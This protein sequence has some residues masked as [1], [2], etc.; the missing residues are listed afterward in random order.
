M[1]EIEALRQELEALKREVG[2][3]SGVLTGGTRMP[4]LVA[5][6][7]QF[8]V[9]PLE[10]A[11]FGPSSYQS[12]ASGNYVSIEFAIEI[13]N[14]GLVLWDEGTP[15]EFK[16]PSYTNQA[17]YAFFIS[18]LAQ[19]EF[20]SGIRARFKVTSTPTTWYGI[21]ENTTTSLNWSSFSGISAFQWDKK[22]SKMDESFELQ[23]RQDSGSPQNIVCQILMF[24]VR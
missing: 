16:L 7:G 19:S 23:L 4:F 15:T 12:V 13:F 10:V 9:P 17:T 14:T 2:V 3:L 8:T 20:S 18:F 1:S 11:F 6:T 24:R 21:I 5:D 22:D